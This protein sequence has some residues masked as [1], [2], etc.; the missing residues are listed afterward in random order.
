MI[1]CH[2]SVVRVALTL[3][4]AAMVALISMFELL[5]EMFLVRGVQRLAQQS[6]LAP[7]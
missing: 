6:W 2:V 7:V 4:E 5:G 3:N 1:L